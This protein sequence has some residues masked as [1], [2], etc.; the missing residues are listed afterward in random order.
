MVGVL[1]ALGGEQIVE[2]VR[3]RQKVAE[4]TNQ[5]NAEVH[6]NVRSAYSWLSVHGCLDDQLN[7]IDREVRAARATSVIKPVGSYTPPL[8][9]FL[10]DAWLNARS[11]QV[12]DHIKPSAMRNYVILYFFPPELQTDVVQLHQLA[13]ELQPLT[14]GEEDVSPAEAG[15][16]QRLIGKIRELQDRTEL[17]ETLLIK[18]GER[19]GVR[20][21][22]REKTDLVNQARS[23]A[24]P[25]V[26]PP[27][28][29]RQ[30]AP[31]DVAQKKGGAPQDAGK[32]RTISP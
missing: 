20:L 12:A 7:L 29:D 3:W 2:Q 25:C 17:G 1:L 32:I 31:G 30:F 6:S 26:S 11:L 28:L 9:V 21:S 16:Y 4:T 13:A 18:D 8:E 22:S 14:T 24:G 19:L 23:W 15:E 5:L 27:N 10:N